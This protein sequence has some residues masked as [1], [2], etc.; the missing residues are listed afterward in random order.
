MPEPPRIDALPPDLEA[1]DPAELAGGADLD[2][3]RFADLTLDELDLRGARLREVL[4]EQVSA[5]VVRAARSDWRDVRVTGRLGS[6]EAYEAPWR[7]VHLVGCKIDYLNLRGADVA[8]V[9]FTDCV[10]D[11]L[12][13]L[14]A[15]ARRVAFSGTR[16]GRLDVQRSRLHDVD[17]RGAT[18]SAVDG[19]IEL[20]GTTV[21]EA[22]LLLLAPLLAEGLG[23]SVED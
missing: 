20:R 13:L 23:L 3:V 2:G 12:D 6:V 18:L 1:G 22:Q 9:S 14:D 10:V 16:V 4:L 21:S 19:V 17:L 7:S 8:D 5:P 15:T 11:E